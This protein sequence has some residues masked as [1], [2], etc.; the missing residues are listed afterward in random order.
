MSVTERI[1]DYLT[2]G[3]F[4]NP[5]SMEHEKVRELLMD[6]AEELSACALVQQEAQQIRGMYEAALKTIAFQAYEVPTTLANNVLA[7]VTLREGKSHGN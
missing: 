6:C 7:H 1:Q 2:N 5:E 3:G 4:F